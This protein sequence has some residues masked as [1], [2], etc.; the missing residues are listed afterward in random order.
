MSKII[1]ALMLSASFVAPAFADVG[2]VEFANKGEC[3]RLVAQSDEARPKGKE[4]AP[5]Q[6]CENP[7]KAPAEA[8]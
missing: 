6:L 8:E 3:V 2:T 4:G 7:K 1:A 5:G